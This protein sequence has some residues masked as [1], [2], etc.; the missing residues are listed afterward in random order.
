MAFPNM[1]SAMEALQTLGDDLDILEF[2]SE[3]N[4]SI[5]LLAT[6]KD[7]LLKKYTGALNDSLYLDKPAPELLKAYFHQQQVPVSSHLL[8]VET[9]QLSSLFNTCNQLL[10]QT[11]FQIIDMQRTSTGAIAYL[12]NDSQ[13]DITPFIPND[14]SFKLIPTPNKTLLS[15]FNN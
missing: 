4:Q 8:T 3:L 7:N 11:R 14:A 1:P 10:K 2:G 13:S 9:K 15:Y 5:L 6:C 12:A